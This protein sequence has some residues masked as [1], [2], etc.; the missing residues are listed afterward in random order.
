MQDKQTESDF[1]SLLHPYEI[2]WVPKA[3]Q[4]GDINPVKGAKFTIHFYLLYASWN[5][6]RAS[7]MKESS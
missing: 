2:L 5:I 4:Q 1:G 6:F 3:E 7:R